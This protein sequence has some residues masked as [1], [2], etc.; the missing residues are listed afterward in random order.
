VSAAYRRQSAVKA[1]ER[2]FWRVVDQLD[3]WVTLARLRVL[4]ALW[5]SA[6]ETEADRQRKHDHERLEKALLGCHE[7][8]SKRRFPPQP[9]GEA[10]MW[11]SKVTYKVSW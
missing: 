11:G 4:D 7:P 9:H 8:D 6:P 5:G 3:Y 1:A 10:R 2:L